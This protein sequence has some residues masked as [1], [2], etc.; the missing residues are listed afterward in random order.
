MN[1]DEKKVREIARGKEIM[2]L[3]TLA[4]DTG[5]DSLLADAMYGREMTPQAIAKL[6]SFV[7]KN[8]GEG[9]TTNKYWLACSAFL[10]TTMSNQELMK[11]RNPHPKA[12]EKGFRSI[13]DEMQEEGI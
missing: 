10:E 9:A 6:F 1:V 8:V 5:A 3:V 7:L 11:L 13:L 12:G 4:R 2:R